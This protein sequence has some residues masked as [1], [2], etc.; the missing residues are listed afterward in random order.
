MSDKFTPISIDRLL[1]WILEEERRGTIF[2]IPRDMFFVPHGEDVFRMERYGKLL[3]TPIGVAAGPHTQLAQNIVTSWLTGAR[4]IELKTVQT[5]DEIDVVRPCIDMEDEGYNCEWSQELKLEDSFNEYLNA[6]I[7]IHLL[8]GRFGWGETNES[9][10]I[11]NMS[12]G[13]DLD[14]ILKAN[15]QIFLDRMMDCRH[16]LEDKTARLKGEFTEIDEIRIPDQ[17]SDNITISTMHGCP[18]EEIEKI[19]LYFIIERGLNTTIKL[20]PTLLGAE[21]LRYILNERMGFEAEAPDEAF[22]H[23]LKYDDAISLIESLTK[24]A[25]N[26]NVRFGLKLTNTL[27]VLNRRD[28]LPASERMI[29]LS[30]R[31]LHPISVNLGEKLQSDFNGGLDISFCAGVDCFNVSEILAC[32][33][34]P[35]TVCS[36]IL[37]PGGYTRLKQ[38][39]ENIQTNIEQTGA[40]DINGY[41]IAKSGGTANVRQAG[42]ANL[43]DYAE[44]VIDDKRY[45]KEDFPYGS[46]KGLRQLEH[47]DCI[48]APCMESCA[49]RQ[50]IPDYMH[51]TAMGQY[52]DALKVILEANPFPHVTGMVCDHL[53]QTKCVRVCYDEPVRIRE[54]KR[55]IASTGEKSRNREPIPRNGLKAGIIGGGPSGLACAYFLTLAGFKVEVFEGK[56]FGGG[57]TADAIPEFRLDPS[58]V[59]KD[60]E[61][62]LALGVNINYNRKVDITLFELLRS[63]KDYIYIAVGAQEAS[64]LRIPGEEAVRVFDQLSFL[65]DVRRGRKID[66]GRSIV[67]IGGGNSAIDAARTAKRLAGKNGEVTVLYRRTKKE[68][69]ADRD[70][71]KEMLNEGIELHELTVPVEIRE[72]SGRVDSLICCKTRLTEVDISG[73]PRPI[74]IENS[75]FELEADTVISA[76]GQAVDLDFIPQGNLKVDPNSGETQFPHVFAGGDAVRGASTLIK[77]IADG[78][79]A[80][81][82]II[83]CAA[84]EKNILTKK[85]PKGL[86]HSDYQARKAVRRYGMK[87]PDTDSDDRLSFDL[88]YLPMNEKQARQEADRCFYCDDLCDLC[89]SVCPNRAFVSY[90]VEP[91]E[92][93]IQRVSGRGKS[94][95]ISDCGIFCV[96]QEFQ[97]LN[98]GDFC[99]E[100]GNC[101]TFCPTNGS[102]YRD[103]PRFHLSE[104]SFRRENN[105]FFLNNRML[106]AK[107]NG[108][109][110]K[111]RCESS[112]VFYETDDFWVKINVDSFSVVEAQFKSDDVGSVDLHQAAE[113]YMLYTGIVDLPVLNL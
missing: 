81:E 15:V 14:G 37:K 66:V 96:N 2:G 82:N 6:W 18:P 17:I 100:C 95:E 70:E 7:I 106:H 92:F 24:A 85:H 57:M 104:D 103:K 23:D 109:E 101:A 34:A 47:F 91:R 86:K 63:Q 75:E 56:D 11:F 33:M 61:A 83:K 52:E 108:R 44:K 49:V 1:R 64:K 68:M 105:G 67:I 21:R 35:V 32:G 93:N 27:E 89:V 102:P 79:R 39:L 77:A 51:L 42:L 20:N 113:M 60:I 111:L 54:V 74:I 40:H 43:K 8:K 53:C 112:Y 84:A 65:A 80:A 72:K 25:E 13:Y 107:Y 9:G 59:E 62:I 5:L 94:V 28:A 19:G 3:E 46:I 31:A 22:E 41:I 99:N 90:K 110:E 30:G 88:L 55:F 48:Q 71:L 26:A 69:P 98:I 78:K 58:S 73:R 50:N 29:Y 97:V 16:E 76:V 38:Y 36:D 45:H 12:V 10:C 87:P 4:Y